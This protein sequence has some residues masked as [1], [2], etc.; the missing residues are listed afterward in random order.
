MLSTKQ[1]IA[2][3]IAAAFWFIMFSPWTSEYV[4]FWYVMLIATGTLTVM[5]FC[6]DRKLKSQIKFN[7]KDIALGLVSAI[8]LWGVFYVGNFLSAFLFDFTNPQV[9]AIYSMKDGQNP[10]FLGLA[11]LF[12]IG[13]AEELFWRGYIQKSMEEKHGK[14]KAFIFA[15]LIYAFVHIWAFNFMLF[16]A[17]LIC[18][19]FWGFLY[20]KNRNLLTVLVSHAIWDVAVFIL[21]PIS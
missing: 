19:A 3:L 13:P 20:M 15:T 17:A 8:L 1:I 18:G 12:W 5:S 10:L 9:G 4:N 2:I 11:L 14:W 6:F 16:M 21:F 7:F